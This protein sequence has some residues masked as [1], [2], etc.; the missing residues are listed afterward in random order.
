MEHVFEAFQAFG[1]IVGIVVTIA[2]ALIPYFAG[3]AYAHYKYG[4]SWQ[5]AENKLFGPW[6][7]MGIT[8][9]ILSWVIAI[10]LPAVVRLV[11]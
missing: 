7:V 9:E 10:G 3:V 1:V 5:E 4:W 8:S 2:V 11:S 6:I